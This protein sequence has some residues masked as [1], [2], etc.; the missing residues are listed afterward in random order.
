MAQPKSEE[1]LDTKAHFSTSRNQLHVKYARQKS[2]KIQQFVR[3]S[4]RARR[5]RNFWCIW[6]SGKQANQTNW[7]KNTGSYW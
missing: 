7:Q 5:N 3:F 6:S 4:F 2:D 1:R